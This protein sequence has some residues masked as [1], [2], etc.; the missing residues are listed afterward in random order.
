MSVEREEATVGGLIRDRQ[1]G[2][3]SVLQA[4][5]WALIE[6]LELA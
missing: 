6:G 1:I 4:E 5:A 2:F 3:C